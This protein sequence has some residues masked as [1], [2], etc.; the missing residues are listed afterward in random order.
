MNS[1]DVRFD[2]ADDFPLT[3]T[4]FSPDKPNGRAA[5][6][7]SALGVPR[8]FYSGFATFLA[9]EGFKVLTFDYR[10]IGDS[11]QGPVPGSKM[12]MEDWGRLDLDA[13][14]AWSRKE[15]APSRLF[16]IGHSAGGQLAGLA[17]NST[18]LDGLMFTAVSSAYWGHWRGMQRAGMFATMFGIVPALS[19]GRDFYPPGKGGIS[20]IPVPA[21]VTRQWAMWARK[22][23]Y[24]YDASNGIDLGGYRKI[25]QPLIA[26]Q[27]DDDHYAP[28]AAHDA[29][30]AQ[31]P[32]AAIQRRAVCA[33]DHGGKIGHFGF[34]RDKHR[35]SLWREAADWLGQTG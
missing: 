28:Q 10:G 23:G 21:G 34:Y 17:H 4:L 33:E 13:A 8:K 6:I 35:D 32:K 30:L 2:C 15:L 14:L 24:L 16:L 25:T 3:G 1:T 7:G 19:A 5:V 12:R 20:S 22:P 27:F 26:F 11:Y 31:F 9:N 18:K 29:V